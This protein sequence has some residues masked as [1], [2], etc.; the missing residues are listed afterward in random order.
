MN[1]SNMSTR[2]DIREKYIID[3]IDF[4][5]LFYRPQ[6]MK[7]KVN[8]KGIRARNVKIDEVAESIF[9]AV[10]LHRQL[11]TFLTMIIL[12]FCY[13]AQDLKVLAEGS[14]STTSIPVFDW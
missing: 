14:W 13:K 6:K 2:P 9:S 4:T 7:G 11:A 3:C 12:S 1:L 5:Y 10:Q 8:L